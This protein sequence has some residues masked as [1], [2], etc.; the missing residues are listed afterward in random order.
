M[1]TYVR[2]GSI[3]GQKR[4]DWSASPHNGV[5]PVLHYDPLG[6]RVRTELPNGTQ[7]HVEL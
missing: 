7:A 3:G 4:V 2:L 5:T 1:T 6:R